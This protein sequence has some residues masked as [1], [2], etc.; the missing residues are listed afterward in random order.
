MKGDI[1]ASYF[2]RG[3][4]LELIEES[5]GNSYYVRCDSP[6][7]SFELEGRDNLDEAWDDFDEVVEHILSIED[8]N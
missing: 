6:Y 4:R 5:I 2:S 3:V 8:E 7:L 1:I